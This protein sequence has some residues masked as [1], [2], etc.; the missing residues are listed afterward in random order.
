MVWP[1]E[2]PTAG[3]ARL[4]PAWGSDASGQIGDG[5]AADRPT[6]VGVVHPCASNGQL[7]AGASRRA[8]TTCAWL[9]R[10]ARIGTIPPPWSSAPPTGYVKT[11]VSLA[12]GSGNSALTSS[13]NP[14]LAPSRG[15]AR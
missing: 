15:A 10:L 2:S 5:T 6:P 8:C 13:L 11:S 9:H 12:P 4:S 14:L 1:S 3:T 7:V